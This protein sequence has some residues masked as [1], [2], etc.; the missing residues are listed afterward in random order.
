LESIA[1]KLIKTIF[2]RFPSIIGDIYDIAVDIINKEKE[3]TRDYI[4]GV[5]GAELD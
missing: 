4:M 3:Q 5:V 1:D 2:M